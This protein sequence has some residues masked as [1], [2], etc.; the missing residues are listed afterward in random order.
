MTF[1]RVAVFVL[2]LPVLGAGALL[3]WQCAFLLAHG[4]M[5]G[6]F[7]LLYAGVLFLVGRRAARIVRGDIPRPWADLAAT[8][9]ADAL[10]AII[11]LHGLT[12]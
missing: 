3:V 1:L 6:L 7:G 10:L 5:G 12:A 11:L 4:Q 8:L 9:A 2:Y